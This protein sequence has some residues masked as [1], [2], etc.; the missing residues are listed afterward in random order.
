M[1]GFDVLK[2][3]KKL[4]P[5]VPVIILTGLGYDKEQIDKAL[6]LGA[7]GYVSKAMPVEQTIAAIKNALARK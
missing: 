1:E 7:S 4:K 5:G 2:K 3:M 6:S